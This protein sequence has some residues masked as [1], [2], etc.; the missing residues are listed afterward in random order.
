MDDAINFNIYLQP[1]SKA[2]NGQQGEIEGRAKTKKIA[3]YKKW[4]EQHLSYFL[5]GYHLVKK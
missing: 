5:K 2:S 1:T 4:K 3:I